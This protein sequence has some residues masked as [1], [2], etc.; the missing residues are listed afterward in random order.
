MN[1]NTS[2]SFTVPV[3]TAPRSFSDHLRATAVLGVPLVI[4]Q[5]SQMLV[6]VTDTLMLGWLGVEP[7]AAGV[8]AFQ[9]IFMVYIFGLGFAAALMPL[10][11]A[12]MARGDTTAVRRSTRMAL[13]VLF[14]VI[15]I[16]MIPLSYGEQL[17]LA[18]GQEADLSAKAQTYLDIARWSMVP[19]FLF[20]GLRNF[21]AS[22]EHTKAILWITIGMAILNA[23]AN[24]A[25]IF[26]NWGA[27]RLEIEGAAY[28]TCIANST[29]FATLALYVHFSKITRPYAL[30]QRLWRPEWPAFFEIIRLGLPIALTI[31]AEVGLFAGA[32]IMIGWLGA[33]QLAAHGIAIQLAGLAFMVPL[34]L[35]QAAAVRVGNAA[36]RLDATGI[37]YAARA[38]MVLGMAFAVVAAIIFLI[39]PETLILLY[40]DPNEPSANVVLTT[41][42]GLLFM[43]ALFQLFDTL[44]VTS[45]SNLRGLKDTKVPLII[46]VISYWPIGLGTAYVIGIALGYGAAGVWAGLVVGLAFAGLGLTWRFNRR[47]QLGLVPSV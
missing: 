15:M 44:Q 30:F 45:L 8:L 36:G 22:L 13:W 39:I 12:A 10:V 4:M 18:L 37:G 27:P 2:A 17:L 43:A 5:I 41:A 29:A 46:A 47:D 25:L 42:V 40:L 3:P 6:N 23:M 35:S 20:I 32:S 14:I 16:F 21:L 9:T 34:G 24:Y 28:A 33:E 38:A 19:A 31:V 7:L 11:G 26:G 1:E